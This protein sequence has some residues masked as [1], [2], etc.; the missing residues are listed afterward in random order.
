V[1]VCLTKLPTCR[2]PSSRGRPV[3]PLPSS[4]L[5]RFS[6]SRV[7]PS[8]FP[9]THGS[10]PCKTLLSPA[11]ISTAVRASEAVKLL[12]RRR[13]SPVTPQSNLHHQSI[14]GK[15]NCTPCPLVCLTSP[16]ASAPPPS[17]TVGENRG[18]ICED[19]KI[20]GA[21]MHKDSIPFYMCGL[22]LV[23]SI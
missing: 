11:P 23:K 10:Y 12:L 18:H 5:R 8:I 7:S 14:A 3:S 1:R 15:A 6:E 22:K 16:P 17:G 13:R 21:C 9:R 2:S 4:P 20:P 19:L